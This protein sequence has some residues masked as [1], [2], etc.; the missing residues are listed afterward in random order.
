MIRKC[1]RFWL[2]TSLLLIA[3]AI[4]LAVTL[5]HAIAQTAQQDAEEQAA[6]TRLSEAYCEMGYMK[7][8]VTLKESGPAKV[9]EVIPGTKYKFGEITVLGV[10]RFA[11]HELLESGPRSGGAFSPAQL[12]IW[13]SQVVSK[14]EAEG[15]SARPLWKTLEFDDTNGSIAVTVEFEEL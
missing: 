1:L 3:G 6:I 15:A 7:T 2:P 11:P 10:R 12:R 8:I 13:I 9:L 5:P 4:V 14:Y